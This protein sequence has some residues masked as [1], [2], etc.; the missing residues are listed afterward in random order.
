MVERP[1][2]EAH[3]RG[4]RRGHP[5]FRAQTTAPSS[6]RGQ[7][8][9][10]E[11]FD[12]CGI[13]IKSASLQSRVLSRNNLDS[14]VDTRGERGTPH[15]FPNG[16]LPPNCSTASS[17]GADRDG[18][19]RAFA[20][21]RGSPP[22]PPRCP[23]LPPPPSAPPC[24]P[25]TSFSGPVI[26]SFQEGHANASAQRAPEGSP[27][28]RARAGECL[29][30]DSGGPGA[31]GCADSLTPTPHPPRPP[32]PGTPGRSRVRASGNEAAVSACAPFLPECVPRWPGPAPRAAVAGLRNGP[33]FRF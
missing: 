10:H 21:P 11:G 5:G 18:Q 32:P 27:G 31:P 16:D 14:Q 33:T 26:L 23:P 12:R 3:G 7:R 8:E 9:A 15:V 22:P 17:Q 1:S 2:G 28:A 29:G 20:S 25:A 13:I 30:V 19:D 4:E 6:C 24:P